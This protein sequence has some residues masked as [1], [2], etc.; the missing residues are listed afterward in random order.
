M[1]SVYL[2]MISRPKATAYKAAVSGAKGRQ[3]GL[4]VS[5]QESASPLPTSAD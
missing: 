3:G 2:S 1:Y 5:A 4:R